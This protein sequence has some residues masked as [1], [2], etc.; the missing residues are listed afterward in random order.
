MHIPD[1]GLLLADA[2]G[3]VFHHRAPLRG[4]VVHGVGGNG[5][6][7]SVSHQILQAL[8][9]FALVVAVVVEHHANGKQVI[10]QHALLGARDGLGQLGDSHGDE[11]HHDANHHHQLD[12]SEATAPIPCTIPHGFTIPNKVYHR[13]LYPLTSCKHRTHTGRPSSWFSDRP[14][15]CA[16]PTRICR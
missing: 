4:V 12:E 9:T 7:V 2:L 6:E 3:G 14:G 11:N 13:E 15:G 8:R 5:A 16:C 1:T 10:A